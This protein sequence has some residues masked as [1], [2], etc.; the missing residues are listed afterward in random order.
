MLKHL[1]ATAL[2]VFAFPMFAADAEAGDPGVKE[3]RQEMRD[4]KRTHKDVDK[5]VR[6]WEK[7][8]N[9]AN[10]KKLAKREAQLDE[11]YRAELARLRSLGVA[12][13][14]IEPKPLNPDFP[15][16]ILRLAPEHPK[17]E[18][19]RDDLVALRDLDGT[20]PKAL[21]RKA[22]LLGKV[23]RSVAQRYERA[24]TRLLKAKGKA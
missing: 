8:A 20:G 12:T 14:K 3:A 17:M 7:A 23:N 1:A 21:T 22:R 15:N 11:V 24:E 9:K 5:L 10:D 2:L 13:K 4:A 16:K 6:K 19:L 18:Q